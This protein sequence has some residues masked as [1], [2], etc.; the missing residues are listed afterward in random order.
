MSEPIL[1]EAEDLQ[2]YEIWCASGSKEALCDWMYQ[3]WRKFRDHRT[4]SDGLHFLMKEMSSGFIFYSSGS[5]NM[6]RHLSHLF[7]DLKNTARDHDYHLKNS[8]ERTYAKAERTL[9]VKRHYLKPSWR[10]QEPDAKVADQKYGNILIELHSL[11]KEVQ[12]LKF[13]VNYYN[14]HQFTKVIPFTDMMED[15]LRL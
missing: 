9:K 11:K 2:D 10:N 7:T 5:E 6:Q 4:N 1:P 8:D 3:R 14:D 13:Q 15:F 12:Y